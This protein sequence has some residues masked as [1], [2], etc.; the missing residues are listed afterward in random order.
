MGDLE[1]KHVFFICLDVT[2]C[3][4][5]VVTYRGARLQ[6]DPPEGPMYSPWKP[7]GDKKP[8]EIR[9]V[10]GFQRSPA[11]RRSA[12]GLWSSCLSLGG[13]AFRTL[14][15]CQA[16]FVNRAGVNSRPQLRVPRWP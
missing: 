1:N 13:L 14:A 10:V 6:G 4:A 16:P 12:W 2:C 3:W 8:M 7:L 15:G 11:T 5:D 9:S